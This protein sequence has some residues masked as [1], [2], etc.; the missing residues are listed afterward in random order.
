MDD[1]QSKSGAGVIDEPTRIRVIKAI[2]GMDS[3][4]FAKAVGVAQNT[5]TTWESG[6]PPS[7]ESRKAIK[8]LCDDF[9]IVFRR[10]DGM[11][12]PKEAK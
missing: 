5:V 1:Q 3:K 2:L 8:T 6:R 7:H 10:K 4:A 12:V 9:G 11:P